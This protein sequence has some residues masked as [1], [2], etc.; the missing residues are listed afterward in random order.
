MK[1]IRLFLGVLGFFS[2]HIV[3]LEVE[4]ARVAH[5]VP[6]GVPPPQRRRGGLAVRA[7]RPRAPGC[8]LHNDKKGG[9]GH[10]TRS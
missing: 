10:M 9:G 4:A 2:T 7:R 5:W 8:G 3:Q 1:I 6:V